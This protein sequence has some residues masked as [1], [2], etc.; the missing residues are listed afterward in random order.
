[1]ETKK[2]SILD[3]LSEKN[4]IEIPVWQREFIWNEP[5]VVQLYEDIEAMINNSGIPAHFFGVVLHMPSATVFSETILVDGHQRVVATSLFLCALCNYFKADNYKDALLF[6]AAVGEKRPKIRCLSQLENEYENI[7]INEDFAYMENSSYSKIYRFFFDKIETNNYSMEDY[8]NA[9][10]RFEI[11]DISL[12]PK[13]NPQLV[14]DSMNSTGTSLTVFEKIKNYLFIGLPSEEQFD[15][16]QKYWKPI[17]KLFE[18]NED[19]FNDFMISYISM[20]VEKTVSKANLNILFNKFYNFKRKYKD[21]ADIVAE[22]FKFAQ[23][24]VRIRNTDFSDE[25]AV[26]MEKIISIYDKPALYSFLFEI[27]DDFQSGLIPKKIYIDILKNTSAYLKNAI[28]NK[29][30]IDFANLSKTI[31]KLLAQKY[32]QGD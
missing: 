29:E 6:S 28:E 21:T 17:E 8:F 18:K 22:I 5:Q 10:K 13:D 30:K 3:F 11:A 4:I 16:W 1:M 27:T 20:Q 7:L 14:Y 23:Y 2:S 15:I 19:L 12:W 32:E 25:I 31:S 26:E 9:L 24:F